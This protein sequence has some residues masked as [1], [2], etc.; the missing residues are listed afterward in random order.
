[1]RTYE[2]KMA[3]K[4]NSLALAACGAALALM[5]AGCGGGGASSSSSITLA[6]GSDPAVNETGSLVSA[7][8]SGVEEEEPVMMTVDEALAYFMN[9]NP[10][11]LGLPE[12]KMSAYRV[13]PTEKAVPVDGIPCMKITV[14]ND[15]A[16]GTNHPEG[17]FLLAR[18]GTAL[19]RLEG[20]EV[21]K[22]EMG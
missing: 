10:A 20:E 7:A 21:T 3:M 19:Y 6:Q 15:S 5:L 8:S 14:Y 18:D 4:L 11:V 22:V 9:L 12:E 2:R 13:Y 16:A 17:T 1:M